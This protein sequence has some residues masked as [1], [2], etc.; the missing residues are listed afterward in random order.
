MDRIHEE[1]ANLHAAALE[2]F[3][4]SAKIESTLSDF[5]AHSDL[6]G[7]P[8]GYKSVDCTTAYQEQRDAARHALSN[9]HDAM[10]SIASSLG[11][12]ALAYEKAEGAIANAMKAT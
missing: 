6:E 12:V 9:M 4:I 5:L 10:H 11:A 3:D 2:F 1:G 8:F 7:S